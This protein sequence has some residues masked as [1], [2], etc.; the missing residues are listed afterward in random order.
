MRGHH[1]LLMSVLG[2]HGAVGCVRCGEKA[3]QVVVVGR[4]EA[5]AAAGAHDARLRVV[6]QR[7]VLDVLEQGVGRDAGRRRLR[8]RRVGHHSALREVEWLILLL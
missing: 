5:V 8:V 7:L 6:G 3:L 2:G 4:H 1:A